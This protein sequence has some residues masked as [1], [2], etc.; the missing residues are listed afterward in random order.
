[1]EDLYVWFGISL[2]LSALG[3]VW[4]LTTALKERRTVIENTKM[5][6][7][8]RVEKDDEEFEP[9][10]S[11]ISLVYASVT[12]PAMTYA[13]LLIV[14]VWM[15]GPYTDDHLTIVKGALL[16]IG[17]SSFFGNLGRSLMYNEVMEG[18]AR[19]SSLFG[20]YTIFLVLPETT[21]IHGLLF[22]ILGLVFSGIIEGDA[23]PITSGAAEIYFQASVILGMSAI[24][25]VFT[26]QFF[27]RSE[28]LEDTQES[29]GKK[30]RVSVLPQSLNIAA[31]AY[32]IWLL[33]ESGLIG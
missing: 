16:C 22:S 13:V 12:A 9:S 14:L 2:G 4:A 32:A 6:I 15:F 29:F 26:G 21:V 30:I 1:M 25:A 5:E 17:L 27:R 7:D 28:K 10:F 33:L 24:A 11:S 3:F 20:R 31:L 8:N 19:S 23:T 18:T